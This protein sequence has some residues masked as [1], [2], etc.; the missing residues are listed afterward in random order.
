MGWLLVVLIGLS[1]C[2]A[3]SATVSNDSSQDAAVSEEDAW[4]LAR[5]SRTYQDALQRV[6]DPADVRMS[7]ERVSEE[8]YAFW[9]WEDMQT[10]AGT[11]ERLLVDSAGSA[12]RWES[13]EAQWVLED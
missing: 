4:R 8:G 7:L 3:A 6:T 9:V 1:G 2:G 5:T 12:Y 10:H 13:A 11:L